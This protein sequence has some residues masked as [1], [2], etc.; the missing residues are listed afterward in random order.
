VRDAIVAQIHRHGPV[1][2]DEVMRIALY[3]PEH[4]FY[5]TGGAAG[6]RGDFVTSVEVGPLFGAVVARALD[7]WWRELDRPDPF[8]VIEAAAGVGT[9]AR[10]I[11]QAG[12][13]CAPV[14]TYVLV[15]QSA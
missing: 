10:S 12:P 11:L 13:D 1:P 6:R 9:L 2:F 15:E 14:L 8:V 3:D 5:T 4:G 7:A